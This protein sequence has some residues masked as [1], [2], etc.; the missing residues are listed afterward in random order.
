MSCAKSVK[1]YFDKQGLSTF[2]GKTMLLKSAF[3]LSVYLVPYIL[4]LAGVISSVP[5]MLACWLIMG[6]GMAGVG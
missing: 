6:L 4:L 1:I 3:M 5:I 2:G